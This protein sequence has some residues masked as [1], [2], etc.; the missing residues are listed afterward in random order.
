MNPFAVQTFEYRLESLIASL[1]DYVRN[2]YGIDHLN[3]A[4]QM[5]KILT[6]R[7]IVMP[8]SNPKDIGLPAGPAGDQPYVVT[9]E[10]M[11]FVETPLIIDNPAGSPARVEGKAA[12]HDPTCEAIRQWLKDNREGIEVPSEII[13]LG[14]EQVVFGMW[15]RNPPERGSDRIGNLYWRHVF[16][17]ILQNMEVT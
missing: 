2:F 6:P 12:V 3:E 7:V 15:S 10:V 1:S 13:A 16:F 11:V 5:D 17:V 14:C 9:T 8:A 4:G